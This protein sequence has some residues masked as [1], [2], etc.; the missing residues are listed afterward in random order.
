MVHSLI[1]KALA[2]PM[3]WHT[4]CPAFLQALWAKILTLPPALTQEGK[5]CP[6]PQKKE[7]KDVPKKDDP[8]TVKLQMCFKRRI[9][10]QDQ[11]KVKK[12]EKIPD[13][14]SEESKKKERNY[15]PK[16]GRK[17]KRKRKRKSQSKIGRRQ[18]SEQKG[19]RTKQYLNKLQKCHEQERK[20]RESWLATHEAFPSLITNQTLVRQ[21]LFCRALNKN[22]EKEQ[23]E[24]PRAKFPTKNTISEKALL[25]H[26][27]ACNLWFD[28]KWFA[29][30][31]HDISMVRN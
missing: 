1:P 13:Q 20:E 26:D 11:K 23:A 6:G 12:W 4:S 24:M 18:G 9:P 28:R 29:E 5:F 14:R 21:R 22:R 8:F 16:I 19:L 7:Q 2:K 15:R 3:P 31:S 27:H 10:N 25:I 30:S 17:K